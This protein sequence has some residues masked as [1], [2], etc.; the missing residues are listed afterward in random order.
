MKTALYN[1]RKEELVPYVDASFILPFRIS[2]STDINNGS[3]VFAMVNDDDASIRIKQIRF[4]ISPKNQDDYATGFL[5]L[6]RFAC[7]DMEDGTVLTPV[8]KRTSFEASKLA[9][10][11]TRADNAS[12]ITI[13]DIENVNPLAY[14]PFSHS[15]K[16]NFPLTL[17]KMNSLDPKGDII[18][19]AHEGLGIAFASG[20]MSLLIEQDEVYGLIEW[21]EIYN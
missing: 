8:K 11:L 6:N 13:N 17:G 18:L 4:G 15:N 16:N 1:T 14:M 21:D 2:V 7:E 12:G 9:Q 10:A 3:Y 20:A 5:V 19:E